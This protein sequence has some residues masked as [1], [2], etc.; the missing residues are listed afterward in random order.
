MYE[1]VNTATGTGRCCVGG[2]DDDDD[3]EEEEDDMLVG[4]SVAVTG[5]VGVI[6][7]ICV[8]VCTHD[9]RF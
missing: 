1:S 4:V 3:D 2:V 6:C 9:M 7:V 8:S 5:S